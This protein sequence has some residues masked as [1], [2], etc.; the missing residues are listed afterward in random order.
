MMSTRMSV[1]CRWILAACAGLGLAA[2][3]SKDVPGPQ[4]AAGAREQEVR[5]VHVAA[6]APEAFA[7]VLEFPG[8]VIAREDAVLAAKVPGRLIALS[9]D[10]GDRAKPGDV[11]ARVDP[12][13]SEL[14]VAQAEAAVQAARAVL[15]LAADGADDSVATENAALVRI[16]RV[17]L[18]EARRRRERASTLS[19]GGASS[20]AELDA[21]ETEFHAAE[22]RLQEARE[23]IESRRAVLVQR[24]ADLATA[25]QALED[26]V[27]RSPFAGGVAERL[28]DTGE[29]VNVGASIVRVVRD[30]VVR[31][32][33]RV[34]DLESP[35]MKAGADVRANVAG[36]DAP[37]E[38]RISRV[39][40][41]LD[42]RS[43]TLLVECDVE[44][45]DLRLRPG[46]FAQAQVVIDAQARA[47]CVPNKALVEF[48]GITRAFVVV[49]GKARERRVDVG[50]RER[51][52]VEVLGGIQSGEE[53]VL[54]PGNLRDGD[55]VSAIR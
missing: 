48:A 10:V 32:R 5:Q 47:L 2:C 16:A 36:A 7:D 39:A 30:D 34:P 54:S 49:D 37:V 27:I 8:E 50:R 20:Q 29:Y 21:A 45:R 22:S 24:R 40:P 51:T 4:Q 15:G 3:G 55:P 46:S 6:A 14:R 12:R 31:V 52:R 17:Q 19:Q 18:D 35:R 23:T 13:D 43:R 1:R 53:V 25:R 44:N 38:T 33:F 41:A 42:A 11:V 28:V 9:V 26:T